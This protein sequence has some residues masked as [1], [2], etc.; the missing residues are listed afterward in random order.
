MKQLVNRA[1]HNANLQALVVG[2]ET[3]NVSNYP[4][5]RLAFKGTTFL[6]N[7]FDIVTMV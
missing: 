6:T 3:G 7:S 4:N 2:K 1:N 5:E